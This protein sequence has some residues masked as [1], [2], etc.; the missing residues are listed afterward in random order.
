MNLETLPLAII[1]GG[2]SGIGLAVARLLQDRFRLALVYKEDSENASTAL[3]GFNEETAVAIF[4]MDISSEQSV[5][6]NFDQIT[7]HFSAPAALL[8]NC[9]GISVGPHHF[10]QRKTLDPIIQMLNTNY[11]GTVRMCHKVLPALYATKTGKIIN[12]SSVAAQGGFAGYVG[13]AES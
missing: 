1:T 2:T 13:Y 5:E 10:I 11:L 3:D 8:V 7:S 12:V 6:Q 4:R 9:A